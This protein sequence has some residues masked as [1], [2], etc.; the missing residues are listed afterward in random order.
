MRF[1]SIRIKEGIFERKIDFSD[2]VN[3]IH[4]V[5]N[6]RGKTTLLRL[7]LYGLG[8]C[9]PNTRKMNFGRCEVE[10]W[11]ECHLGRVRILRNCTDMIDVTIGDDETTYILP[12]E[13]LIFQGK[14]FNTEN[15]DLLNNVL[16]AFYLDQEK[17]WTL[18]NRG[19]VIGANHF[20]I[21]ELIRGLSNRSCV[22]LL[23]H[24]KRLVAE[25]KKYKHLFSIAQYRSE[26]IAEQGGL[27]E[28]DYSEQSDAELAAL[29]IKQNDL[30]KEMRRLNESISTNDSFIRFITNMH[31]MVKGP[32]GT[33][34]PVTPENVIGLPDI[35][36]MLIARKKLLA[37]ELAR[38]AR[39]ISGRQRIQI[40]E[41]QQL[42]FL[43]SESM[44]EVVGQKIA[45]LPLDSLAIERQINRLEKEIE[46][47]RRKILAN[48]KHNNEI[49]DNLHNHVLRYAKRLGLMD[50][51]DFKVTYLFTNNLKE[52]SGAILHKTVFA[53]RMAYILEIEKVLGI[54]L[55]I[56]LDSPSGK[57]VDQANIQAMINILKEDFQD[58]QIIIASIFEYDF[59]E[60][61]KIE[62]HNRLVE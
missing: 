39:E 57:E 30:K 45:K 46:E 5:L 56:I 34:I 32:D 42:S 43:S 9:I 37:F 13:Q 16:G 17:G 31:I 8:Y 61:N 21:E 38:V 41:D 10:C 1:L 15:I 62:I 6:S 59:D 7:L 48:T 4:S 3:L 29:Q 24:E 54:K 18:L 40:A 53:F 28:D 27:V 25:I 49:V 14:I 20:N 51:N 26:V 19:K 11:I 55:P 35:R 60:V 12:D 47:V 50:S 58:N 23:Q 22:E 2:K 36:D 44:L 33:S 52:L